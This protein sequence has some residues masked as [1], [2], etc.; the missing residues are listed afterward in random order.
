[1][2]GCQ[3]EVQR[4][5]QDQWTQ[6]SSWDVDINP[7]ASTAAWVWEKIAQPESPNRNRQAV[8]WSDLVVALVIKA[9][10][11]HLPTDPAISTPAMEAAQILRSNAVDG[12]LNLMLLHAQHEVLLLA[13]IVLSRPDI[14]AQCIHFQVIIVVSRGKHFITYY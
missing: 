11:R 10:L 4:A 14:Q 2:V 12:T 7:N 13:N 1:M 9:A 3:A 5:T 8:W 6:I